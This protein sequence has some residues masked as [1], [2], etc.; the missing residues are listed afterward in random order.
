MERILLVDD[1]ETFLF[2]G[3]ELLMAQRRA[4]QVDTAGDAETALQAIRQ[5]DYDVVVSDLRMPGLN[6]LQLLIECQRI[7]PD[8][9]VVLI[10]AYEDRQLEEEA[11]RLGAYA[12]LHKP[13]DSDTF[14][15]VVSRAALRA[16]IRRKSSATDEG[17]SP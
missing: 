6:G 13:L 10:S 3:R 7:R 2:A 17:L 5:H 15:S 14:A 9:P 11:A 1:D 8:I 12:F 4:L 16:F